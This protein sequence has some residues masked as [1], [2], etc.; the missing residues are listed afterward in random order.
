[1]LNAEVPACGIGV[2]VMRW[3]GVWGKRYNFGIRRK[4]IVHGKC[5]DL[6]RAELSCDQEWRIGNELEV[7]SLIIVI[8]NT[9]GSS[10]D[11]G[12]FAEWHERETD[13]R[14]KVIQI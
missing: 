2:H 11:G 7:R 13:A 5:R 9:R 8:E 3:N 6:I 10:Y 4:G 14:R 12:G 1:M